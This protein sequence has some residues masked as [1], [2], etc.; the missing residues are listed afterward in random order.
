[1]IEAILLG[2]L[3]DWQYSWALM[4]I[5]QLTHV[6]SRWCWCSPRIPR[7]GEHAVVHRHRSELH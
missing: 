1:M 3:D 2:C 7:I 5:M 4:G 6:P